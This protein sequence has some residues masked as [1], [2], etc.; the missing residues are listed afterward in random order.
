MPPTVQGR[1]GVCFGCGAR[2]MVPSEDGEDEEINLDF[3]AGRR[4]ADRY[5]IETPIG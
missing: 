4:I 1:W 2:L 5:V 3:E